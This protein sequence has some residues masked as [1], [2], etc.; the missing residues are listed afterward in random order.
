MNDDL[1][2]Y[3]SE[4]AGGAPKRAR[5][6]PRAAITGG[7]A[8]GLAL[9]AGG[10][11]YAATSAGSSA[12]P[13]ASQSP[14]TTTPPGKARAHGPMRAGRLGFGGRG[15]AGRV[16]HGT[17]T[18]RTAS[19][20]KTVEIQIGQ[21]TGVNKSSIT[22]KSPDGFQQTYS[23]L[24]S[25]IVDTQAGGISSV[26][27]GDQVELMATPNSGGKGTATNIVDTTKMRASRK[28][29]GLG[30]PASQPGA[31]SS[32]SSSATGFGWTTPVPGGFGGGGPGGGAPAT[33]AQ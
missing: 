21:V 33:Q 17:F 22:V 8:V 10:L 18:V 26:G 5:R 1:N 15:I 11:A 31:G 6:I 16:V 23:V 4:P 2:P 20:Y 30:P 27:N 12:T 19:G 9:G 28:A 7:L 25:T 3:D 29:F 24:S 32:A 14:S 13:A